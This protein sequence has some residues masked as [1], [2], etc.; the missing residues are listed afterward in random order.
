MRVRHTL[1]LDIGG[2]RT[3]VAYVDTRTGVPVPLA[4]VHHR[5][6][7]ELS[8]HILPLLHDRAIADLVIGLPLLPSG[9]E[10]AQAKTVRETVRCLQL[11]RSI[12]VHFLDERYT[13]PRHDSRDPD[14]A[15]ACSLLQAYMDLQRFGKRTIE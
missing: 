15:A 4:P 7:D 3:G 5:T 11:P 10:G 2:R 13:T 1:A 6:I 12:A 8:A 14:G 9:A